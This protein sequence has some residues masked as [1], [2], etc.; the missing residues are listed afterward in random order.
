ML[1][2]Q[3]FIRFLVI[4]SQKTLYSV[5]NKLNLFILNSLGTKCL[6]KSPRFFYSEKSNSNPS[7]PAPQCCPTRNDLHRSSAARE[8]YEDLSCLATL[9][10]PSATNRTE[11]L[12]EC[13]RGAFDG[14][15]A[16]Y[17]TF[18]S[19]GVTGTID[20]E[21]AEALGKEGVGVGFLC[22]NGALNLEHAAERQLH[23]LWVQG[24]MRGGSGRFGNSLARS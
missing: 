19:V 23:I 16:I 5:L 20:G 10:K 6:P 24:F 12:Q 11:F 2:Y 14:V 7:F 15:K 21:L 1:D 9:I 13:R 17:R 3:R 4:F 18:E 8:A 22:H